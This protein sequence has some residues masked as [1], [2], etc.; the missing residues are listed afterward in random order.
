MTN[1]YKLLEDIK[2][3]KKSFQ[4]SEIINIPRAQISKVDNLARSVR[5]QPSFLIYIDAELAV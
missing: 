5:K 3:L 2:I 1:I 4:S